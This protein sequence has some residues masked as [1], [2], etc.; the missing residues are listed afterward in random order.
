MDIMLQCCINH[1]IE[2]LKIIKLRA[3]MMKKDDRMFVC[4]L[5]LHTFLAG[6]TSG[7][8]VVLLPHYRQ[9]QQLPL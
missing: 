5:W 8:D 6:R 1:R 3:E 7:V 2:L 4:V 9:S